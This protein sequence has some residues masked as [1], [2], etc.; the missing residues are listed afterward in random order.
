MFRGRKLKIISLGLMWLALSSCQKDKEKKKSSIEKPE[1]QRQQQEE[2]PALKCFDG[3]IKTILDNARTAIV[4]INGESFKNKFV[5]WDFNAQRIDT[6][7]DLQFDFQRIDRHGELYLRSFDNISFQVRSTHNNF[8]ESLL[9]KRGSE[10]VLKFSEEDDFLIGF[11][12]R[13]SQTRNRIMVFDVKRSDIVWNA[14][15]NE[16][17]DASMKNFSR[18]VVVTRNQGQLQLNI[19]NPYRGQIERG[20]RLLGKQYGGLYFGETTI[21]V[22]VGDDLSVFDDVTGIQ[23]AIKKINR[24]IDVDNHTDLA[25]VQDIE[26]EYWIVDLKTGKNLY[27][28]DIAETDRAFS[29]KLDALKSRVI[30]VDP[31]QLS[32]IRE[33]DYVKGTTQLSCLL[34]S[35]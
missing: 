16:V 21:S 18:A 13:R 3:T 4:E 10:P 28:L 1:E 19:V 15:F 14:K 32:S 27:R 6:S 30:C 24:V 20:V 34:Q 23:I 7:L 11:Y 5:F 31:T 22:L 12:R 9:F 25:L 8:Q 26:R 35:P 29:C 33:Y 2:E 17:L